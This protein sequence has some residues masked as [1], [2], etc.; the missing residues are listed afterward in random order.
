MSNLGGKY[1][2]VERLRPIKSG[3]RP[4]AQAPAALATGAEWALLVTVSGAPADMCWS[5]FERARWTNGLG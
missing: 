3:I 4:C 2:T 1:T 5:G